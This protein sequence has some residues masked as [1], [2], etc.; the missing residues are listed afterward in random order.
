MK[1]SAVVMAAGLGTRMK[2]E[3]PKVLHPLCGQP[4]LMYVLDTLLEAKVSKIVV[5][6][7]HR[8][9]A[10]IAALR[11]RYGLKNGPF[12]VVDQKKPL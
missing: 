12:I 4:I 1:I 7:N 6:V 10:V 2:S 8:K 5:V 3:L 9:E 11:D